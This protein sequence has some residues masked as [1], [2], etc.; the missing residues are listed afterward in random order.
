MNGTTQAEVAEIMARER[1]S[2][3]VPLD[4]FGR[5]LVT[6]PPGTTVERAEEIAPAPRDAAAVSVVED[7]LVD[8]ELVNGEQLKEDTMSQNS[9]TENRTDG[10]DRTDRTDGA[11]PKGKRSA[12][13]QYWA[14]MT[15]EERSKEI[16]R[17]IAMR[18]GKREE[19]RAAAQVPIRQAAPAPGRRGARVKVMAATLEAGSGKTSVREFLVGER[20]RLANDLA[21]VERLIAGLEGGAK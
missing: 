15:P 2:W 7:L 16:Q 19:R 11:R 3:T 14:R 5:P 20:T 17:R 1:R 6:V 21:A 18:A 4:A 13:A 8:H 9:E 10:T 12:M